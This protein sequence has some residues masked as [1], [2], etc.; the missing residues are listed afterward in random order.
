M[1]QLILL[2]I[3]LLFKFLLKLNS[4]HPHTFTSPLQ[5]A[6]KQIHRASHNCYCVK[7]LLKLLTFKWLLNELLL[8]TE[9]SEVMLIWW[10]V[11][12]KFIRSFLKFFFLISLFKR[13]QFQ[14]LFL[15]CNV[16]F[17]STDV[18]TVALFCFSSVFFF[19]KVSSSF[20]FNKILKPKCKTPFSKLLKRYIC[21]MFL[22]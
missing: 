15:N 6:L 19:R 20:F 2:I 14:C 10:F 16:F 12:I 4:Y 8:E 11:S 18:I 17:P 21:Y 3:R 5:H 7:N 13:L 22:I 1:I 9:W